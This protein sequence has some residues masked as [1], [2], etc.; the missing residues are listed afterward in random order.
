[1]VI[2]VYI[3]YLIVHIDS[4]VYSY[5]H[6][7]RKETGSEPDEAMKLSAQFKRKQQ[8]E[9]EIKS[10][11]KEKKRVKF[12]ESSGRDGEGGSKGK[13]GCICTGVHTMTT[14]TGFVYISIV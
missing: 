9:N 7:Y 3:L 12:I 2:F 4:N 1:V 14:Y 11:E 13:A 10:A 5:M 8:K 6:R